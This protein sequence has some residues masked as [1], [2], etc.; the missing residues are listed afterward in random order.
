M[1]VSFKEAHFPP[2]VLL[3]GVALVCRLSAEHLPY[4]RTLGRARGPRG[5]LHDYPMGG[6]IQ[7]AT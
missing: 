2:T 5:S 6:Q 3:M 7:S 4:R 1:A